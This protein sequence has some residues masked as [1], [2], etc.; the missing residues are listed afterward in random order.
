LLKREFDA[1]LAAK[2]ADV[3]LATAMQDAAYY[4][5]QAAA[6]WAGTV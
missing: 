3:P 2:G 5:S 6:R 4:L 1:V